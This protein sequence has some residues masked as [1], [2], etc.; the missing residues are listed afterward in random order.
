[1]QWAIV[2]LALSKI[3]AFLFLNLFII[4][5]SHK[6]LY[7]VKEI[8]VNKLKCDIYLYFLN[9]WLILMNNVVYV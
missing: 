3:C 1:M 4:W 9:K 7:W 2:S 6:L 8:K 5:I